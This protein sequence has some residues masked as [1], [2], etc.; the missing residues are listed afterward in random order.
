[1]KMIGKSKNLKVQH[2]RA[3]ALMHIV[4]KSTLASQQGILANAHLGHKQK[5]KHNHLRTF[6]GINV[7]G[8]LVQ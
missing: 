8:G 4:K 2:N 6:S 3:V 7:V 1:M 5:H